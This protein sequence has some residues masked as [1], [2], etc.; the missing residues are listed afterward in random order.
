MALKDRR[1]PPAIGKS[2]LVLVSQQYLVNLVGEV[3][4][5]HI[6]VCDSGVWGG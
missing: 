2:K 6:T 5:L 1:Y 4:S 3:W